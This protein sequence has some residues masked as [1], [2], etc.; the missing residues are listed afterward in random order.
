[1]YPHILQINKSS[2][3]EHPFEKVTKVDVAPVKSEASPPTATA[4]SS[5]ETTAA[6]A[7]ASAIK[8]EHASSAAVKVEGAV[9]EPKRD[10]DPVPIAAPAPA[11]AEPE[12]EPK[13]EPIDLSQLPAPEPEDLR[14]LLRA[15][16]DVIAPGK[17][18]ALLNAACKEVL[19][20][21]Y[22]TAKGEEVLSGMATEPEWLKELMGDNS[23]RKL[24]VGLATA[25]PKVTAP[26][27]LSV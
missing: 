4:A 20:S 24:L 19:S 15:W 26:F 5:P 14:N 11:A 16:V 3:W 8:I 27:H 23:W 1:M 17:A 7:V 9:G 13:P 6:V 18:D 10:T 22:T 12:P 25:H 21:S 2:V